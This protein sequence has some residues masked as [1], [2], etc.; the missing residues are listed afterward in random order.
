MDGNFQKG[1]KTLSNQSL[2]FSFSSMFEAQNV[3]LHVFHIHAPL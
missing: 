1:H 2:R 3:S